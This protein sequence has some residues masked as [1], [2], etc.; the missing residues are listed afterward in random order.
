MVW[1][2]VNVSG[3]TPLIFVEEKV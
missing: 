3:E 1:V 2:G